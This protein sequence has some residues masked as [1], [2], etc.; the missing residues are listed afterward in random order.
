MI[1]VL[2]VDDS[3]VVQEFL[4]HVLSSDPEIQIVGVANSGEE[5]IEM[6]RMNE[7]DVITM[8][9]HMPGI[10][11][12]ETTRKIMEVS[13]TP[14]VIVSGSLTI[15]EEA[16]IFRSL[17]AGALAVVQRP[18]GIG[19]P[20]SALS[21]RE[22]IKTVKLMSKVKITRLFPPGRKPQIEQTEPSAFV[23]PFENYLKRIQV[24]AIGA[25]TG[26]PI[27]L[28]RILS[29]L[30]EDLP[31]PVL[32]VQ[33][34]AAGFGR[35]LIEWLSF[36]SGIKLKLAIDGESILAGTGYIAPDHFHMEITNDRKIRLNSKGPENVAKPSI[37][38][39][40]HSV[41]LSYGMNALGVLLT[42]IGS[43]GTEELKFMKE[44]GGLTLVQDEASSTVYDLPRE[45][46]RI[47]AADLSFSPERIAAFLAKSG[48]NKTTNE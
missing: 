21:Q 34:I 47:G 27:I 6:V 41:A 32:I 25:S 40:F 7:P 43:D 19:N 39:L 20:E 36:T 37:N 23:Q 26:G 14:I 3:K 16:N 15:K 30:P 31:V 45:A 22:L 42:G 11:G 38:S 24:I 48:S 29:R 10:D 12:Y 2:I 17:E 33:H 4:Y 13:P 46:L 28:Q 9:I 35:P 1:R 18:A 5:A 44:K 8:D